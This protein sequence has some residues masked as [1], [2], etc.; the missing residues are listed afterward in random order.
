VLRLTPAKIDVEK[1]SVL[2]QPRATLTG[3]TLLHTDRF[4][5]EFA[6]A[7]PMALQRIT[8]AGDRSLILIVSNI[9]MP[10]AGGKTQG[11]GPSPLFAILGSAADHSG[12][13][14]SLTV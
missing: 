11:V 4:T 13:A 8:D 9:N 6:Q 10:G 1:A 7:A 3:S 12:V 2:G 14:R 5:M